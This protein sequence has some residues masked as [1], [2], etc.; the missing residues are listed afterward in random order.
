MRGL[1]AKALELVCETIDLL[2]LVVEVKGGS[3]HRFVTALSED[4]RC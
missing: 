2:D 3:S 4:W 1:G